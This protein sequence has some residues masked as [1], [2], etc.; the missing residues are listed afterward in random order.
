MPEFAGLRTD[1][2]TWLIMAALTTCWVLSVRLVPGWRVEGW[3]ALLKSLYGF[4]WLGFGVD[5]VLR[6]CFLAYNAVEWGNGSLRLVAL[7]ADTIDTVLSYCWL[8]WILF[9]AAYALA[10][11]RRSA[12]PFRVLRVFDLD[13]IYAF[14]VPASLTCSVLLYLVDRPGAIPVAVVTPLFALG[15][16]YVVPATIV[17]WDHF[18]RPGPKWRIGSIP[19]IVLLPAF[20]HGLCSP[21]RENLAPIVLIPLVA[22]IF[23]GVRPPLRKLIPAVLIWFVLIS[24]FVSSYRRVKWDNARPEEVA[25]EMRGASTWEWLAGSWGERMK[26]FHCFDSMLVTVELV[27][28]AQPH[29]GRNVLVRPFL[30]GFVPR[31]IYGNKGESDAGETFGATLWAYEDPQARDHGSAAIAPSM[32][33]DLYEAGGVLYIAVGAIIWGVLLG[34]IDGWKRHLPSFCAA[35]VTTLVALHCA[36]SVE[37]DFDHSVAGLIQIMLLLIVVAGALALVRRDQ[38]QVSRGFNPILERP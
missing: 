19:A 8:F 5:I 7:P 36:L 15:A 26:R 10:V 18:R 12:G 9:A 31:F 13:I 37:R 28:A 24:T 3:P 35:A 2:D 29:S 34:L 30:R 20:V 4:V 16:L 27:P 6:F 38:P 21:Y 23:A 11:R 1:L 22:A 33:G 25:D 14:A 32:P 17:W